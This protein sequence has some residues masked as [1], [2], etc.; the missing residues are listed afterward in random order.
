LTNPGPQLGDVGA[1]TSLQLIGGDDDG[2]SVTFSATGLPPGL[3][4]SGDGLIAGTPT[5]SGAYLVDATVTDGMDSTLATFTWD[6]APATSNT[7]PTVV[8]PGP[9][10]SEQDVPVTLQ[11]EFDDDDGDLVTLTATGLPPGL[12]MD[13]AGEISGAPIVG[14]V[15]DVTVDADDGQDNTVIDFSW[16]VT[17]SSGG[18]ALASL[19]IGAVAAAGSYVGNGQA[20]TILAS[21]KDIFGRADEFHFAYRQLSGDGEIVAR[22]VSVESTA[23]WAKAGVMIRAS[24]DDDAINAMMAV[25]P[26][27]GIEF[28]YR[29]ETGG[30]TRTP[31]PP[32]VSIF[33][34]ETAPAWVRLVRSGNQLTG[35]ISNDGINWTPVP[36]GPIVLPL[37]T[38]VYVGLAVTS[39][40]DGVLT[41]A[42]FDALTIR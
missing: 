42:Q 31:S 41:T 27:K 3:G 2:D 35:F 1:Y 17:T 40:N 5:T 20:A 12:T 11:I 18:P 22:V 15:F 10:I 21:G 16:T 14:G 4:V 25:T 38:D 34:E 26:G 19:D 24:L 29:P 8:N 37:G 23:G 6:I 33:P 30:G 32:G 7:A 9:Q 39:H 13:D 36:T 28:Q